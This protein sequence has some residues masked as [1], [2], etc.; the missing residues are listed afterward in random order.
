HPDSGPFH[1]ALHHFSLKYVSIPAKKCLAQRK[2]F[3]LPVTLGV[4][5]YTLGRQIKNDTRPG[6]VSLQL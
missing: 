2:N 6:R 5:R 1:A 4:F 3:S